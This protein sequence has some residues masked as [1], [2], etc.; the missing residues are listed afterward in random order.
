MT[1]SSLEE[2]IRAN[3]GNWEGPALEKDQRSTVISKRRIQFGLPER[4]FLELVAFFEE[5][6]RATLARHI[7]RPISPVDFQVRGLHH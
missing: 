4:I 5:K 2:S 3:S 7:P 1:N 6:M